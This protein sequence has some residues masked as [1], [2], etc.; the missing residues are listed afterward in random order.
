MS[1]VDNR[2]IAVGFLL[3]CISLPHVYH[4]SLFF[5]CCCLLCC[6]FGWWWCFVSLVF[7]R[8]LV[9]ITSSFID[10]AYHTQRSQDQLLS[11]IHSILCI[12]V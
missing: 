12:P 6:C 10:N 9:S 1:R 7:T 8:I 4:K 11:N 3:M 2:R 5:C